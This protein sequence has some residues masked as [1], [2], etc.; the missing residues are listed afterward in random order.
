[1]KRDD[2]G[3]GAGKAQPPFC[4]SPQGMWPPHRSRAARLAFPT[5]KGTWQGELAGRANSL[6]GIRRHLC[7]KLLHLAGALLPF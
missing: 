7:K 5:A 3:D 4:T 2:T 6:P 1:M